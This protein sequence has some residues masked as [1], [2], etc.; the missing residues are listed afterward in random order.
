MD[1]EELGLYQS[2]TPIL[3]SGVST[4]GELDLI[5]A[6]AVK[7]FGSLR[8]AALH[9]LTGATGISA[10]EHGKSVFTFW[11]R[12]KSVALQ[13]LDRTYGQYGGKNVPI[14]VEAEVGN[15]GRIIVAADEGLYE[16]RVS[17]TLEDTFSEFAPEDEV[18]VSMPVI[19]YS[20]SI[21]N[22]A[23]STGNTSRWTN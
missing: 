13:H 3:P 17:D 22:I 7:N 10:N 20:F 23:L 4:V 1:A 9:H 14:L 21:V 19:T 2:N 6:A 18:F 12:D 15:N 8:M 5:V 11:S 16:E